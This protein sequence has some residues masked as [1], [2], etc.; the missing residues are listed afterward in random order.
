MKYFLISFLCIFTQNCFAIVDVNK[1]LRETVMSYLNAAK[2]YYMLSRSLKKGEKLT[3]KQMVKQEQKN[4][5]KKI[6]KLVLDSDA[7]VS[8]EIFE[9][10]KNTPNL[11]HAL[12]D[13]VRQRAKV[14]NQIFVD[15]AKGLASIVEPKTA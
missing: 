4:R 15:C 6:K 1:D 9:L 2:N 3:Q 7:E 14:K 13:S 12:Q 5:L 10:A 8:S 11:Q